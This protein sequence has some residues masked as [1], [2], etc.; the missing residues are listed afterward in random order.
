MDTDKQ[1][2]SQPRQNNMYSLHTRPSGIQHTTCTTNRQHHTS[3]EHQP[4]HIKNDSQPKLPYNK[5]I[6]KK[7][8]QD[9]TDT[10][11]THNNNMGKTKGNDNRNIQNHNKTH[12][13][14][15]FYHIVTTSIRHKLQII[16]NTTLRIATGCTTDPNTQ[17]DENTHTTHKATHP[18]TCITDK[19]KITTPHTPTTLHHNKQQ[20]DAKKQTTYNTKNN[21]INTQIKTNMTNMKHIHTTIVNTYLNNQK[22]NK[23]IIPLNVYHSKTTLPIATRRTL[24]QL[25]IKCHT[26]LS[27]V[28]RIDDSCLWWN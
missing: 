24:A 6:E 2:H 14:V 19:I 10:Q 18:T 16:Q 15:R 25:R 7:S 11:S 23:V 13:Q 5:H 20:P 9:N 28:N 27:Y 12:T 3:H 21:T 26:L 22:H 17:H 1:P 8:T 4:K